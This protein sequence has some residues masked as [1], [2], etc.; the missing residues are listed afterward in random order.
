[1]E[2]EE[3]DEVNAPI[4]FDDDDNYDKTD[5]FCVG[6]DKEDNDFYSGSNEK[7]IAHLV[8]PCGHLICPNCVK[9]SNCQFCGCRISNNITI[10]LDYFE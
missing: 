9:K 4:D 8:Q 2:F 7:P 1:M 5:L 6:D 10:A 3:E